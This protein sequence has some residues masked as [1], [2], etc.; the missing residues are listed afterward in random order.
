ML[1]EKLSVL[2][3]SATELAGRIAV[4]ANHKH[5]TPAHLL[6]ALLETKGSAVIRYIEGAGGDVTKLVE[7]A[8][9]RLSHVPRAESSAEHTPINRAL[10]AVFI[11]AEENASKLGQRYIGPTHVLASMLEDEDCSAD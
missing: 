8:K 5:V 10:E 3:Q 2:T 1:I 6:V 7:I 11:R 9:R 4:K